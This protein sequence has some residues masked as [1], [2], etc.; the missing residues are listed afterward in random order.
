MK[1]Y[2]YKTNLYELSF[3]KSNKS[4]QTSQTLLSLQSQLQDAIFD[5]WLCMAIK[6]Y[7][8]NPEYS[9]A[10]LIISLWRKPQ[11]WV[12]ADLNN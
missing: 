7:V 6:Y 4:S 1:H 2:F 11:V 12:N 5:L 10:I 8:N 3:D 9:I